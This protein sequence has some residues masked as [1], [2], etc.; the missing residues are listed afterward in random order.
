MALVGTLV[1]LAKGELA[2]GFGR[3]VPLAIG[4][5]AGAQVGAA[6][7]KRVGG[8]WIMRGL[9]VALGLVGVRILVAALLSS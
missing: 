6:L 9:A 3:I 4:V 1:H 2:P 7:S 8:V 5:V